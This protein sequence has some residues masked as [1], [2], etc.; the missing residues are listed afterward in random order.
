MVQYRKVG[1]ILLEKGVINEKQLAKAIK[2]QAKT[3]M[4]FGEILTAMG[5]A[6]EEDI[7]RCLADQYDY[8]LADLLRITPEQEAVALL[9]QGF[10]ISHLVLPVKVSADEF[11]CVVSDPVDVATTDL[12]AMNTRK[13]VRVSLAPPTPLLTSILIAYG[14]PPLAMVAP[15]KLPAEPA[16]ARARK[17][18]RKKIDPQRDREAL[19]AYVGTIPQPTTHRS[20]WSRL[21]GS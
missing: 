7:T 15:K 9:D 5:A 21:V 20:F 2:T 6:S 17:P 8:P 12:V 4:R 19:L 1:E 18:A 3:S 16:A 14:Q 13:R 11:E 10:A